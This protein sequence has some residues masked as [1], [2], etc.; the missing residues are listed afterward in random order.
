MYDASCTREKIMKKHRKNGVLVLLLL[1]TMLLTLPL[2]GCSGKHGNE[3]TTTITT[4]DKDGNVTTT[5]RVGRAKKLDM[6]SLMLMAAGGLVYVGLGL[7]YYRRAN[8][9]SAMKKRCYKEV[10][11]TIIRLD[12]ARSDRGIRFRRTLYNA[13]YVYSYLG[14]DYESS[15]RVFGRRGKNGIVE[16]IPFEGE[17]TTIR[18]NPED[19]HEIYD[20][21]TDGMRFTYWLT[22]W[23]EVFFA[24][25][26]LLMVLYFLRY[27]F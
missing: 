25:T 10:P 6:G 19:I 9:L 17:K 22:F 4:I 16:S 8:E 3:V 23:M 13:R 14:R 5:T 11:A 15:N 27:L 21:I 18:I 7:M 20:E 12:T 1:M 26:V 24:V 2:T